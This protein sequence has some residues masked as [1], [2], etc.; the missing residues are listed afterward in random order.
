MRQCT[1]LFW[2]CIYLSAGFLCLPSCQKTISFNPATPT[3]KDH[4]T[5]SS[6]PAPE[7][8]QQIQYPT[9]D[10]SYPS[11]ASLSPIADSSCKERASRDLLAEYDWTVSELVSSRMLTLPKTFQHVPGDFPYA[12]YWAYN[13]ELSKEIGLDIRPHLGQTVV[14]CIYT[15]NEPLPTVFSPF[16]GARAVI[17]TQGDTIVGAWIEKAGAGFGCSLD[18]KQFETIV[19]RKW[20]EWLVSSGV[21]LL[22]NELDNH[23]ATMTPEEIIRTYYQAIEEHD[24]KMIYAVKSR[25]SLVKVL[26]SNMV[27]KTALYNLEN[28]EFVRFGVNN[29]ERAELLTV[30]SLRDIHCLPIYAAEVNFRFFDPKFP[31]ISEGTH[32]TFVVMNREIDPL[33]WRIEE[34][35]TAPGVSQ[36]LCGIR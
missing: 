33:G 9:A 34:I 6:Q 22:S 18:G 21:V 27:D 1:F 15:L 5:P 10:T 24:F 7:L 20:A 13:N 30:S 11:P 26:F 8:S 4:S 16:I 31:S 28:D 19:Q 3:I 23:L 17:L 25:R 14:A 36:R 12:I 29:I 35:N 2:A 32:P